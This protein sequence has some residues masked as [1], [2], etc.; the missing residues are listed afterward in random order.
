MNLFDIAGKQS[1]LERLEAETLKEGFWTNN[2]KKD[3][4][5]AQISNNKKICTTYN[6]LENEVNNVEELSE[7]VMQEFDEDIKREVLKTTKN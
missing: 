4:I 6:E 2:D 1:E 5:L 3:E 7:L